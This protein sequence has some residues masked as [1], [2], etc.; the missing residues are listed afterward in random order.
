M[1]QLLII[2]DAPPLRSSVAALKN[3]TETARLQMRLARW[4][5][6]HGRS[7]PQGRA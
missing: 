6:P 3:T 1:L 5:R 4:P 7:A 2:R